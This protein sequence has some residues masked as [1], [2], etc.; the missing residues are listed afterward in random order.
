M[1]RSAPQSALAPQASAQALP[2]PVGGVMLLMPMLAFCPVALATSAFLPAALAPPPAP[3]APAPKE[4]PTP[5]DVKP[6]VDAKPVIGAGLPPALVSLLRGADGPFLANEVFH[7]APAEPLEAVDEEEPASEWYAITR[8]RFVGVVDQY[9]LTDV[10]ISGVGHSARK[11]YST[12]G[13]ALRAFNRV[14]TWG[15]VQVV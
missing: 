6:V 9:A 5:P 7:A 2:I 1:S 12:Q 14:L 13:E 4:K 10:A 3:P 11:G 15:G 8:G